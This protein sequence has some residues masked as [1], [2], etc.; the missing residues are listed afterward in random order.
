MFGIRE[1]TENDYD[2]LLDWW[3][4]FRF[5]APPKVC[6]PDNGTGGIM[7]MKEGVP[8]CAGF[9]Y[10]TNSRMCWIEYIVSNPEYKNK[11]RKE[12]IRFLIKELCKMAKEQG[13]LAAFTSVK[14][15]NLINHYAD[16]GF[17]KGGKAEEMVIAFV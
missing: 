2:M 15:Q 17:A 13:F 1:L 10:Y 12:A 7:V 9:V 6:L 4:W 11:D 8:V 3:K 16:C 14:N 5:P